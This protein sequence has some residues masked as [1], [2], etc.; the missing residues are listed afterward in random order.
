MNFNEYQ[1]KAGSTDLY[2][3]KEKKLF[4][5]ALVYPALGLAGESGEFVD[6][7]KKLFRDKDGK[8]DAA[9]KE[10]LTLELGDILWYIAKAA[11]SLGIKLDVVAQKNIEKIT[12]RRKRQVIR[13]SGDNR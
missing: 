11:R 2:L 6:K 8:L 12:S 3:K 4:G 13:G 1:K 7:I 9:T 5:N 10:S